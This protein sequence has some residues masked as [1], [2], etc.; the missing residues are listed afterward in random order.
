[1]LRKNTCFR[2][3]KADDASAGVDSALGADHTYSKQHSLVKGNCV[4]NAWKMIQHCLGVTLA[5]GIYLAP[6]ASIADEPAKEKNVKLTIDY[7][8]GVQKVFVAIPWK[9][10]L[11]VFAA[12]EAAA[13]HPRGIKVTQQGTGERLLVTAIDDVKNEGRGRN[14]L[15][16]V[17]GKLAD[18]SAGVYELSA[19]DAI[20]WRFAKYR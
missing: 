14:W 3:A 16:E 17:N 1:L 15:Y 18:K 11:T 10:K 20:L 2:G 5:I 4:M 6:V 8:D 19:G 9:E 13:R 7:G 12:L